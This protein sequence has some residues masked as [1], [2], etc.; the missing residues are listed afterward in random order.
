MEIYIQATIGVCSEFRSA[1][2]ADKGE[3]SI[4]IAPLK[5]I[6]ESDS[7]LS[8]ASGCNLFKSCQNVD[9]WYS[10]GSRER[11]KARPGK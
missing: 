6:T 2:D 3:V 10:L 9:C 1:P 8:I 4:V 5:I 7:K 11:K